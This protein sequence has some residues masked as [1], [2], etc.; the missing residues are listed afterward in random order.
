M[1]QD[2]GLASFDLHRLGLEVGGSAV[3]GGLVGYATKKIAK[4]LLVLVGLQLGLLQILDMHGVIEIHWERIDGSVKALEGIVNTRTPPPD[5]LT[6][7]SPLSMGG[8][9]AGGFAVG[10]KRA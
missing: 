10:F 4:L 6:V 5:I 1:I 3:V 9:F 8:G 2:I 7:L